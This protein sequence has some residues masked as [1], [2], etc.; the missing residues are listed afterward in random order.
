LQHIDFSLPRKHKTRALYGD[1]DSAVNHAGGADAK[2]ASPA[3]A[4]AGVGAV[5]CLFDANFQ[6]PNN[7]RLTKTRAS[8]PAPRR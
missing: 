1:R 8:A 5:C 3:R 2:D 7:D 4:A 6:E